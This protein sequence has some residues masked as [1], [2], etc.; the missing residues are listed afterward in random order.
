M[1]METMKVSQMSPIGEIKDEDSSDQHDQFIEHDQT[2]D[3]DVTVEKLGNEIVH[4]LPIEIHFL[5]SSI[6]LCHFRTLHIC[7]FLDLA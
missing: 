7:L 5:D 1:D 2:D 3:Y 4:D 6:V